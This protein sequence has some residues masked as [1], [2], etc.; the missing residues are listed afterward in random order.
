M[1]TAKEFPGKV[2]SSKDEMLKELVMHKHTLSSQKKM[3][4][5]FSDSIAYSF[6]I[7]EKDEVVKAEAVNVAE[8]NS[9]K[10]KVVI[11]TTN[12]YDSHGDVSIDGSWT[13][14]AKESKNT[15]LL[16]E[17]KM[18]FDKII[19]DKVECKVEK[20]NWSDLGFE[21][22]GQTEALVFY[23]TI[24]K[25][26][27]PFMFEQYAKG[28]VKEHSAGLRYIKMDFAVNSEAEWAKDEK[29]IWDKYYDSIANKEDVDERGYFWAI[30]EQKIMEGSA[31][32]KGSNFATP[33]ISIEAVTDTSKREPEQSTQ[34][35]ETKNNVNLNLFI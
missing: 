22:K 9:I 34:Q 18:T 27:N 16:Q 12:I 35:G 25:Q 24:D 21:F 29:E 17:H 30:T 14:T 10:I 28:Y 3:I 23:V 33:T 13:K 11:N 7:N 31:V 32:V 4:T 19:S 5:K 15:L 20:F 26:R 1:I 2:F 8:V 6:M